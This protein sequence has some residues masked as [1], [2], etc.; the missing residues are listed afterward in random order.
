MAVMQRREFM[1]A[2]TTA[3]LG[4][5]TGRSAPVE[6]SSLEELAKTYLRAIMTPRDLVESFIKGRTG[7]GPAM[8]WKF[9]AE[10][11]WVPCQAIRSDGI[12]SD[13]I[14]RS[15]CF[16]NYEAD[17]AR[18][19]IHCPETPC[20]IHSYGDSFT[21]GSQVSD[22][23]TWQEYLAAHFQEPIRN[24]GVGGYS[25][26]QAYRRMLLVEKQTPAKYIS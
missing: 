11:G 17:G 13:G 22:G 18:R 15:R 14:N 5:A 24:Y 9:D 25:V 3:A 6:A 16:Y 1:L 19:V 26:F 7:E 12:R 4:V 8:G 23:E 20:R 2:A 21:H 10:L